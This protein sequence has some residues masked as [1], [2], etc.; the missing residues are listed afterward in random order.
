MLEMPWRQL[1]QRAGVQ[2]GGEWGSGWERDGVQRGGGW[3]SGVVRRGR[4]R[5]EQERRGGGDAERRVVACG[6]VA[7]GVIEDWSGG[8]GP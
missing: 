6:L 2:R 4:G 1:P 7:A 8:D 3:G 5:R